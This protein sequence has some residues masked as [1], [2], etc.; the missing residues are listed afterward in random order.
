MKRI[1]SN[2]SQK[3]TVLVGGCFDIIHF[4]HIKFLKEAKKQGNFLIV[5]LESDEYIKKYK[6]REPVHNQKQRAMI[7]S[8]IK[9]V[10]QVINLPLMTSDK[11][12]FDLVKRIKP[13][14]IAITKGDSQLENKIK[15]AKQV[16]AQLKIV[17]DFIKGFSTKRIIQA[18]E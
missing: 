2:T 3:K 5:A 15:Q 11:E 13:S 18:F 8:S 1:I 6:K 4:G 17:S 9:F 16:R 10:D 7:L 14:V 12:Y